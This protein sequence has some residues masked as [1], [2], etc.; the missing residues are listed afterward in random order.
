MKRKL[1]ASVLLAGMAFVMPVYAD[2]DRTQDE[3]NSNAKYESPLAQQRPVIVND[4]LVH[5]SEESDRFAEAAG[6]IAQGAASGKDT[7]ERKEAVKAAAVSQAERK[8]ETELRNTDDNFEPAV[9]QVIPGHEYQAR[10]Q[11]FRNCNLKKTYLIIL[12][13]QIHSRV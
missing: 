8:A 4:R 7:T 6:R 10:H 9:E 1:M 12:R 11:K 3:Y 13:K 5:T 2:D